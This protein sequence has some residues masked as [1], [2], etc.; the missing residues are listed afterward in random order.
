MAFLYFVFYIEGAGTVD[1]STKSN[2]V[3]PYT[4]VGHPVLWGPVFIP[5]LLSDGS[6]IGLTETRS[7]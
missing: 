3:E 2:H 4:W 7:D 1:G 5:S 6:K